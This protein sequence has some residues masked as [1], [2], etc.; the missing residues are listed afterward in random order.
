M[1]THNVFS[2]VEGSAEMVQCY[3]QSHNC[4][5]FSV[6]ISLIDDCRTLINGLSYI[7][8]ITGECINFPISK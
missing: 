8:P 5:G 1:H 2:A 7:D 6:A 3:V 4:D